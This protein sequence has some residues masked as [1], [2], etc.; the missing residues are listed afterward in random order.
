MMCLVERLFAVVCIRLIIVYPVKH[1][2][3]FNSEWPNGPQSYIDK[4]CTYMMW[5]KSLT[6]DVKHMCNGRSYIVY[7]R[8][9]TC[10][11]KLNILLETLFHNKI[12]CIYPKITCEINIS[13]FFGENIPFGGISDGQNSVPQN[14]RSAKFPFAEYIVGENYF[15]RKTLRRKLPRRKFLRPKFWSRKF[16]C[17]GIMYMFLVV[18][19]F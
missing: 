18:F 5:N 9:H 8:S 17:L 13:W 19:M 7:T 4:K 14:F 16:I 12:R 15:R 6:S 11:H 3:K 1:N 2:P 10:K